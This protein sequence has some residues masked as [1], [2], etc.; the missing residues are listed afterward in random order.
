VL[1]D[2]DEVDE[3]PVILRRETDPLLVRDAPER[4]GVDRTA[5]MD[6]KLGQL[7]AERVWDL[8]PLLARRRAAHPPAAARGRRSSLGVLG[9]HALPVV[10][11]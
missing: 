8:A 9:P 11:G 10:I 7:V 4:G 1:A 3:F 6:V 2:R 5:E